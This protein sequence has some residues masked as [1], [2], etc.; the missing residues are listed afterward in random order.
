LG[1]LSLFNIRNLV[2]DIVVDNTLDIV[3]SDTFVL[4]LM[5]IADDRDWNV[6]FLMPS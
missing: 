4:L 2:I 1:V 5:K 3:I 6:T